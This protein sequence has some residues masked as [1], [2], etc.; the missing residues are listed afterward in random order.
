MAFNQASAEQI[1]LQTIGNEHINPASPIQESNLSIDW[2]ARAHEV[3]ATKLLIDYVQANNINVGAGASD[4]V[5]TGSI[6]APPADADNEKGAVVQPAK[7]KVILRNHETGEPLV[8]A[9]EKE[10][11]GRLTHDGTDYKVAFYTTDTSGNEIAATVADATAIDIQFPQRFDLDTIAETFAANEKFVDGAA[12][13]ATRMDL[14]QLAKD[15]FGASYVYNHTGDA[16][17]LKTILEQLLEETSGATNTSIRA[18]EIIDEIVAARGGQANLDARLDAIE[19]SIANETTARTNADDA[20]DTRLDALE[21]ASQWE[22]FAEDKQIL[23]GDPLINES[24]YD[25]TTGTFVPGDKSLQV[26]VNGMLQM[27][28]VHYTEVVDNGEGIAVDFAPNLLQ[29]GY[30]V[31]LRWRKQV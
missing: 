10:I 15:I 25:L 9:D 21:S 27:V 6:S 17:Q 16:T 7:N 1:R 23:A 3:L 2:A 30:V 14:L 12:D 22:F 18:K 26:Y 28:G 4:V 29:E 19:T 8:S 11:Y 13:I 20:I 5:V 24:R 31:Q